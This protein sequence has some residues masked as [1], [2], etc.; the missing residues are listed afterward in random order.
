[1]TTEPPAIAV[2]IPLVDKLRPIRAQLRHAV[3]ADDQHFRN[4]Q[5]G[6]QCC[7]VRD[8]LA[9]AVRQARAAGMSYGQIGQTIGASRMKVRR[10][11]RGER[12]P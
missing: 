11:E 2:A 8:R 4:G 1:M 5:H 7:P 12:T 3:A 9:S 6:P 10:I